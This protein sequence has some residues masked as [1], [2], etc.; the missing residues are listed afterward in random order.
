[1]TIGSSL[2]REEGKSGDQTV[3]DLFSS[4]WSFLLDVIENI[5]LKVMVLRG[6][7]LMV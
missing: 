7:G 1:M 3:M 2:W 5:D 6:I 4:L